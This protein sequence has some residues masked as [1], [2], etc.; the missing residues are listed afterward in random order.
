MSTFL[1][2]QVPM[3]PEIDELSKRLEIA[4]GLCN[5]DA[6]DLINNI[7]TE[8]SGVLADMSLCDELYRL[9]PEQRR[10]MVLEHIDL[11]F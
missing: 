6:V 9:T 7:G 10:A 8:A 5:R 1:E 3:T 11:S 2:R 4:Y